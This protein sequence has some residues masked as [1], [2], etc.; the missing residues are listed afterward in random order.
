MSIEENFTEIKNR[1]Y[2]RLKPYAPMRRLKNILSF[3]G[4]SFKD[5]HRD[6]GNLY[7]TTYVQY[8]IIIL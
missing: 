5:Y 6:N 8:A 1:I 3:I 4:K 7:L 2:G